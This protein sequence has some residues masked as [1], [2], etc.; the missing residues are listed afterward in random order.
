MSTQTEQARAAAE[1]PKYLAQVARRWRRAA[2]AKTWE[3]TIDVARD[4]VVISSGL[5]RRPPPVAPDMLAP[6]CS[7]RIPGSR[8]S[9]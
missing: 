3:R 8:T 5:F 2:D 1:D 7:E 9:R 6:R 4:R